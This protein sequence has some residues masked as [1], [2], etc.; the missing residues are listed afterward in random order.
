LRFVP[1]VSHSVYI[2]Q[3]VHVEKSDC[4]NRQLGFCRPF[5]FAFYDGYHAGRSPFVG[6]FFFYFTTGVMPDG[7]FLGT[8]DYKKRTQ[9]GAC[10]EAHYNTNQTE[11]W[12]TR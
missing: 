9:K 4:R 10:Q 3:E 8:I 2:Q 6:R 7:P 11:F 1:A 5:F 12:S